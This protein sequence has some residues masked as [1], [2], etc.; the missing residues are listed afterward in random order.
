M[1]QMKKILAPTDLS[2]SARAGIRFAMDTAHGCG[3]EI[4]IYHVISYED[5]AFPVHHGAAQ[6]VASDRSS[7]EIQELIA[8]RKGEL[9]NYVI[10]NFSD[11]L[12]GLKLH[13]D[14]DIGIPA[15]KI[16]EKA[17]TEGVDMIVISTHGRSGLRRLVIGSVTEKVVRLA[18]CP[19][20]SLRPFAEDASRDK[21]GAEKAA[22]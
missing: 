19:V 9:H 21:V 2:I 16:V 11:A 20:L 8:K 7:A 18:A 17:A 14:V 5:E 22:D 12:S 6:W 4:I 1:K 10:E 13:E 15:E 3:A